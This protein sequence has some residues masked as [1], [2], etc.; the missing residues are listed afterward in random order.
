MTKLFVDLDVK[1]A[2]HLSS[3]WM[4][5]LDGFVA[6]LVVAAAVG[7]MGGNAEGDLTTRRC[8]AALFFL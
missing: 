8:G 4:Q 6:A 2:G 3:K 7:R 1:K 5:V